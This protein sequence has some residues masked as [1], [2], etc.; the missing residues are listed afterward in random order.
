MCVDP[1]IVDPPHG[2]LFL[3]W[4]PI[5]AC[6]KL[7]ILIVQF[8]SKLSFG[9]HVRCI[10]SRIGLPCCIVVIT[11]LP[12]LEDFALVRGAA[13][14]CYIY[15]LEPQVLFAARLCPAYIFTHLYHR[16]RA[17]ALCVLYKWY[18]N[19]MHCLYGELS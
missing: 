18:C 3:S 10:D 4:V 2:K 9:A 17:A 8:D 15:H 16:R 6:P 7:G 14:D 19:S 13:A 11:R 1:R 12:I 5:W